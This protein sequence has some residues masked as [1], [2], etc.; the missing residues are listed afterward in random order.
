MNEYELVCVTKPDAT[1]EQKDLLDKK[2]KKIL[3]EHN[4]EAQ[5]RDWGVRRLAYPLQNYTTAQYEQW[6]FSGK[7]S[8][9]SDIEK[10]LGYDD[11]VLRYLTVKT[12]NKTHR[13]NAPDDFQFGKI[14][15][16]TARKTFDRRRKFEG[17]FHGK[18][19]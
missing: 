12:T 18:T 17:D 4:V 6:V 2:I 3:S 14:D 15:W 8:L 13:D 19:K 7:G 5:K 10:Q 9:V 11:Q 16:A 1:T